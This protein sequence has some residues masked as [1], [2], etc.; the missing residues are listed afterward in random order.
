LELLG[1]WF[2]APLKAIG[3]AGNWLRPC[4]ATNMN[5]VSELQ[6]FAVLVD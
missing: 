5:A 4:G 1:D 3:E 6:I 2:V